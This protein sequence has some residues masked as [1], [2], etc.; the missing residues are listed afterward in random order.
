M[1]NDIEYCRAKQAI[2]FY[3]PDNCYKSYTNLLVGGVGL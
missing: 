1:L 3:P 2:D